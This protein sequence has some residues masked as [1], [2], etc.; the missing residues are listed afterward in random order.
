MKVAFIIGVEN[1]FPMFMTLADL[2]AKNFPNVEIEF[3]V[4]DS[5]ELKDVQ[6]SMKY[7]LSVRTID[8]EI[9]KTFKLNNDLFFAAKDIVAKVAADLYFVPYEYN[10]YNFLTFFAQESGA[11]VIHVQHAMWGSGKFYSSFRKKIGAFDSKHFS[12]TNKEN[13]FKLRPFLGKI[14]RKVL[15]RQFSNIDQEVLPPDLQKFNQKLE[16]F[17]EHELDYRLTA[18]YFLVP[19]QHYKDQVAQ[20]RPQ[21]P[22][23]QVII[24]GVLKSFDQNRYSRLDLANK[25]DLDPEKKWV[26]YLY[27]NFEQYP[28]RYTVK[29][30]TFLALEDF[31]KT[32]FEEDPSVV[33]VVI[34][35]PGS[36]E[37]LPRIKEQLNGFG[38]AIVLHDEHFDFYREA[39]LIV[40]AKST[41]L[42]EACLSGNPVIRQLY[43]LEG[44]YDQEQFNYDAI[45]MT[46]TRTGFK[47][48]LTELLSAKEN[49][50]K[51]ARQEVVKHEFFSPV[52]EESLVAL[53]RTLMAL[54]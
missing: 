22:L 5:C 41:A 47:R 45:Y 13:K 50:Y 44:I 16:N 1:Q 9:W 34:L 33:P 20:E 52:Q 46:A 27:S 53:F 8:K 30:N 21:Y 49:H 10:F 19:N 18:D 43:V 25:Y 11:K 42:M 48:K 28:N 23:D 12:Q 29:L 2:M 54:N 17:N 37:H 32:L 15:R 24:S 6:Q 3:V 31:T 40:G 36:K 51:L 35:H 14:K 26:V 4:V 39:E 38:K 7:T